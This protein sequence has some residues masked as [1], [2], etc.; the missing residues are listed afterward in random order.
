MS[1]ALGMSVGT[2]NLAAAG[3]GRAP[4]IRRAVV[5]LFGHAPP[6][7]GTPS[8]DPA[9]LTLSGFVERVGDPVPLV[10]A[11]G[12]SYPAEQ[13]L[14][15]ALETMAGLAV[16]TQAALSA[17]I[18]IAVPSYWP[19]TTTAALQNALGASTLLAPDGAAAATGFRCRGRVD[20]AERQPR[21]A[22]QRRRRPDRRRRQRHQ[23]HAGRRDVGVRAHRGA[24]RFGDLAGDQ[25]DQDLL[26]L[27]LDKAGA[28]D[29]DRPPR[30]PRWPGYATTAARPKSGCPPSPSPRWWWSG[31][32]SARGGGHPRGAGGPDRACP[33]R[34]VRCAGRRHV[35]RRSHPGPGGVDRADRRR[36]GHSAADR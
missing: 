10:A 33:R 2:T 8:A 30:S 26:A 34:S 7:V 17:D 35:A 9:G 23:R 24:T 14:V 28:G 5:T 29:A 15:E 31:P 32:V 19:A 27:V 16:P 11:D 1:D 12:S 6:Q 25:I 36:S 22:P 21:T 4:V 3:V 18:A 13:L 20:V